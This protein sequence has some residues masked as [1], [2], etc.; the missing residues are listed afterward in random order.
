MSDIAL[1]PLGTVL[2]PG[3]LLPLRIFETRYTDMVRRCM[4]E[5]AVFGVVLALAGR[6]T[7]RQV[8]TAAIGCAA[9]IVDFQSLEDGLLGILC[10]GEQRFRILARSRQDDGLN[11]A[12]VEWLPEPARCALPEEFQAVVPVLRK[13]LSQLRT[14]GHLVTPDYESAAWVGYRLAELLPLEATLQQEMLESDDPI[15]RLRQ[16]APLLELGS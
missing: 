6:D 14:M 9:R 10:R 8:S 4:R 12:D 15:G 7:D 5:E 2:F 13:A 1:F 3:G 16:L 11:R